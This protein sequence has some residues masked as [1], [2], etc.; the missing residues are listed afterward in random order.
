[1]P[2]KSAEEIAAAR[3]RGNPT[4]Q[5]PQPPKGM[6]EPA[7]AIWREIVETR[8]VDYFKPGSLHLLEQFCRLVVVQRY[9]LDMLETNP[10][11]SRHLDIVTRASTA[12]TTLATKLRLSIQS[13]VG[14]NTPERGTGRL[15][16]TPP[17]SDS[18]LGGHMLN[19]ETRKH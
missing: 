15:E 10:G 19:I 12:L 3:F 11:S 17:K 9:N 6:P 5:H 4:G 16:E 2:R 18:L 7:A 14:Q 1:M 8:A 13:S